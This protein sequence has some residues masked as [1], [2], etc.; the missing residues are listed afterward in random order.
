MACIASTYF[1][2]SWKDAISTGKCAA[3]VPLWVSLA[4]S[5][6]HLD[7]MKLAPFSTLRGPKREGAAGSV[8]RGFSP[9]TASSTT[10]LLSP[11]PQVCVSPR[12][13]HQSLGAEKGVCEAGSHR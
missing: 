7:A 6:R 4:C 10:A 9:Q 1:L 2:S 5:E 3:R 12:Q 13:P 8:M 11:P